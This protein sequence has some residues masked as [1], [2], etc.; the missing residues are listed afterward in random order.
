MTD[1][2]IGLGG[3]GMSALARILLQKGK[4][5]KGSDLKMSPL[6]QELEKEGAEVCIGHQKEAIQDATRVIYS[7]GIQKDNVEWLAA[8][9]KQLPLFHRSDLLNELMLGKKTLL[10]SGTHGKTTTTAL[11]ASVL[12]EANL[13]PSFVV[14]GIIRS[15]NTNGRHGEG[16]YFVA[17]GDESDGSFLKP[18]AYAAILTNLENDHLDYWGTPRM[19]DLAFQ[20]FISQTKDLFWCCDDERLQQLKTKGF[21]Y[22]FSEKAHFQIHRFRQTRHGIIFDLNEHACIELPLF[23]RHNALNGAAVYA[24][25]MHLKISEQI[26]RKAFANF[27][28]T[29]RRL[30]YKGE[31]HK[32]V[33]FDDYGHHPNEIRATIQALSDHTFSRRLVV[34][35]QPHRFTRVRDL[36][37]EFTTCFDDADLVVMTDIYSAGEVPIPGITSAAL[38]AKMR[39]HMGSKVHFFPRTHLESGVA[40]LLKPLDVVLTIGAG[41]VTLAGEPILNLFQLRAPKWTV[42]VL[43]GGKSVEHSVSLMSAKNVIK[44]LDP[45]VYC[46]KLF[47]ITKEGQWKEGFDLEKRDGPLMTPEIL[48]ELMKC[49]LC[50]PV[51]HGPNGEDGMIAGFLE[52]LQI[53]YVGCDYRSGAIC[54]H[55]AWTKQIAVH[56]NV[57]VVPYFEMD[58]FEPEKLLKKIKEHFSYPVWIKPVHLGSSIGVSRVLNNEEAIQ[59]AELAFSLDD[60]MIVEKEIEGRQIEFSVVGNDCLRMA[61]PAE[62]LNEGA[63]VAYEKK[64]GT[65]AME[66]V[67]ARITETEKEIGYELAER[68]YRACNCK[69]LA[70]VDFFLD[71]NG[72]FWLNE[73]NPFPGCT[74]TSAYPLMWQASGIAMETVIDDWVALSLKRG[75]K[76]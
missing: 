20:Q 10:V 8:I 54:M 13:D 11:L 29:R 21:S 34:V 58:R 65:L 25:A 76:R 28:G 67:P 14:G 39:D 2:F 18:A 31:K 36:F 27:S 75:R 12:L 64:Y 1:H 9:E 44:W 62:I 17:E 55:K 3:I 7:S 19:L 4:K 23:G 60:T 5:V 57:P 16:E 15:L 73:I 61:L 24:L 33:V 69:G 6:L 32:V 50:I 56:H 30:E 48:A 53:P 42:A 38:Y 74:D 52:T 35:F 45:S 43:F 41:D 22:G 51:F 68:V 72:H 46:V 59:A 47:G 71:C 66:I 40:G 26:I 37:E 49:D 63:F 70:R